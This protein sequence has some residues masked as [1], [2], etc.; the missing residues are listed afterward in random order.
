M[1]SLDIDALRTGFHR[2]GSLIAA[3]PI[4]R[5]ATV[6]ID[7]AARPPKRT[8]ASQ[9]VAATTA[10]SRAGLA[11]CTQWNHFFAT[12]RKDHRYY[13]LVEDTLRQDFEY[14]YLIIHSENGKDAG[15]QPFFILDQDLVAGTN[16]AIKSLIACVRKLW[17]RFLRMRTLMVGCSAG[18]GHFSAIDDA[19]RRAH[20]QVLLSAVVSHARAKHAQLIVLKEFPACYREVMKDFRRYDFERLPSLPM[21]ILN[22]DYASFDDYMKQALRRAT[23]KDLRRQA[24]PAAR[25]GPALE[26][27]IAPDICALVDQ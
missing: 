2:L 17:P 21:T 7:I 12:Q 6:E 13:E 16:R 5:R 22:I 4:D 8:A 25:G 26:M 1:T 20:A 3:G 27:T 18:E 19:T 15:V 10:V 24:R 14:W 9:L 23:S 11:N